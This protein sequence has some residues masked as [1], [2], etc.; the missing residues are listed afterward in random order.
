MFKTTRC[1]ALGVC[2]ALALAFAGTAP[3]QAD[4]FSFVVHFSNPPPPPPPPRAEVRW[5]AP[6]PE[7]V[8]IAGHWGFDNHDG[9]WVWHSGYYEY[10]PVPWA[11][12][13]PAYGKNFHGEYYWVK[14]HWDY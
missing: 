10:P 5:T 8:W 6:S 12:W 9:G 11:R 14:G 13:H 1:L 7:H 4:S 2:L 3:A